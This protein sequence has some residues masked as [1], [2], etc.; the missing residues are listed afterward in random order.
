MEKLVNMATSWFDR[1]VLV[2]GHTGFKGSWLCLM[3][4]R[5]GAQ[6]HGLALDPPPGSSLFAAAHVGELL[7][8]DHRCD[9]RNHVAICQAMQVMQPEIIFHLAA[10]S[11]VLPAYHDPLGTFSTNIM[12]TAHVLAAACEVPAVRAMVVVTTDKVYENKEDGH[13]FCESDSL[14]GNDPYS[15]S[16][17]GAELVVASWRR[18]F[19][20]QRIPPLAIATA[21][22]GNVIGGGDWAED[23]LLPDCIRAFSANHPVTLRHPEAVRP[24]Q[25]VL[26]PLSGYLSLAAKLLSDDGADW[27]E[28]WNFGPENGESLSVREM[29][30]L[31]AA[32]WGA[33]AHIIS[34]PGDNPRHEAGTLRLDTTKARQKLGWKSRWDAPRAIAETVAWYREVNAGVD[35]RARCL[36]QIEVHEAGQ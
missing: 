35:A 27:A 2:T 30:Q 7:H 1:R 4:H 28:S 29:A 33:E 6:V 10:Q 17:A 25:H 21:R 13:R 8:Q 5:L 11:L 20:A 23:R 31:A 19:A 26:D 15:A 16:K 3:L 22:S 36:A 34:A 24:W 18:S 9:I 12:G 14:G 32:T